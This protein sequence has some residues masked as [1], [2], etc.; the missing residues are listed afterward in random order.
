MKK[1]KVV[2]HS[3]IIEDDS[4][5]RPLIEKIGAKLVYIPKDNDKEF[6]KEIKD[7]DALII[8]DELIN[9]KTVKTLK[10]CKIIATQGIGY[11]SIDLIE[12][13]KRDVIVTNVP[14]YCQEE[15]SDFAISLILN[16]ARNIEL[17]DSHVKKGIF[18][19]KSIYYLSDMPKTR[20]LSNQTL[21]IVGFG[22]IAQSVIKKAKVF[23]FKI[24]ST[25]PYA[26]L[27]LAKKMNIEIV[28]FDELL[29]RSD[30]ISI[31]CLLTD[32]NKHM[33]NEETFNKMKSTA[34]LINTGRGAHVDQNALYNALKNRIIA[35]A[36]I[37]VLETEPI[38]K[39]NKLLELDNIILTPHAAFYSEDSFIELRQKATKEVIRVLKGEA[40]LNRVNK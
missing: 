32:E 24:I 5:E 23:G 39:N 6:Y 12:T 37:D 19:F 17:Y 3:V 28:S 8:A 10:K 21:G 29:K 2:L 13:K 1:F 16:L 30:Y 40:P 4:I 33:F 22:R 38:Q 20:R 11:D 27:E 14:D 35:K 36:A 25:D 26:N 15:V 31:H 18:D 34:M 9:A 7:A